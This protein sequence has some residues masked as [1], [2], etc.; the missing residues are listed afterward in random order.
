MA[1]SDDLPNT[2][3]RLSSHARRGRTAGWSSVPVSAQPARYHKWLKTAAPLLA[4]AITHL[5]WVSLSWCAVLVRR[6][7][8][9]VQMLRPDRRNEPTRHGTLGGVRQWIESYD[10]LRPTRPGTT[11]RTHTTRR[12]HQHRTAPARLTGSRQRFYIP[13]MKT[14]TRSAR[15]SPAHGQ[16]LPRSMRGA[17]STGVPAA[18]DGLR[19]SLEAAAE[20]APTKVATREVAAAVPTEVATAVRQGVFLPGVIALLPSLRRRDPAHSREQRAE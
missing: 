18:S 5:A 11:R 7:A 12:R 2:L 19:F 16:S 10:T 9:G 17:T 14:A 13:S 15:S 6:S 4:A 20:V 1:A 3:G 8:L